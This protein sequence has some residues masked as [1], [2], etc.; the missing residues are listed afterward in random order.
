MKYSQ[1][2][3]G[4]FCHNCWNIWLCLHLLIRLSRC[5]RWGIRHLRN[6]S[7]HF[8]FLIVYKVNKTAWKGDLPAA[9]PLLAQETPT[10]NKRIYIYASSGIRTHDPSVWAG[11]YSRLSRSTLNFIFLVWKH[12][13]VAAVP[14]RCLPHPASLVHYEERPGV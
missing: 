6:T 3:A 11:E 2:A 7:F 10:Q 5:C 14:F 12:L 9:R 1:T 4:L 13:V 8:N